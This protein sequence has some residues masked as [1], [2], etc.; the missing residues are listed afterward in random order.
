MCFDKMLMWYSPDDNEAE[1][2]GSADID[3]LSRFAPFRRARSELKASSVQSPVSSSSR[4]THPS[5]ARQDSRTLPP[6]MVPPTTVPNTAQSKPRNT[7]MLPVLRPAYSSFAP[8]DPVVMDQSYYSVQSTLPPIHSQM[9]SM[10][11]DT[12]AGQPTMDDYIRTA[13]DMAGYLTWDQM[14]IPAS[15]NY[16][17]FFPT[18]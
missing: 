11:S 7:Q 14:E 16:A 17:N 9:M 13:G 3:H 12:M 4:H 1:V 18:G 15:L 10:V 5:P 2:I 8:P 6:L